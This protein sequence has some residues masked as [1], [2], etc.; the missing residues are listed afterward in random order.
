MWCEGG[1][2]KIELR[3]YPLDDAAPAGNVWVSRHE[4]QPVRNLAGCYNVTMSSELGRGERRSLSELGLRGSRV[5]LVFDWSGVDIDPGCFAVDPSG[6]L[7]DD[8]YFI[9]YNQ[10]ESPE[11]AIR[12]QNKEFSVDLGRLPGWVSRLVF[13]FTAEGAGIPS[14]I[15]GQAH[16]LEDPKELAR[17]S[18]SGRDYS[19]EHSLMVIELYQNRGEWKINALG[20]GFSGGLEALL[21]HFGAEVTSEPKSPPEPKGQE[22][23]SVKSTAPAKSAPKGFAEMFAPKLSSGITANR[24]DRSADT[25]DYRIYGA[26]T[27][28][29]EVELDPE[30]SVIAEAGAM[31]FMTDGI[32]MNTGLDGKGGVLGRLGRGLGRMLTGESFFITTFANQGQGKAQVGFAAPYP[33]T[34]IPLDLA[35]LGGQFICQ[36]DSFLCAAKGV[37]VETFFNRKIGAGL[38]GGEGFIL[39]KL[40]GE[41]LA[42]IHLGGTAIYREL[43]VGEKV[44]IDTGC[45]VGFSPSVKYNVEVN[46]GFKNMLFGGEGL[47]LATLEGPGPIFLQSLPFSRLVDRINSG[48]LRGGRAAA[49]GGQGQGIFDIFGG[50]GG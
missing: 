31:C 30:E 50:N 12:M 10:L 46:R 37:N 22:S 47:V 41:G 48:L 13:T 25:V 27:Q 1:R 2:H 19:S 9:F 21:N 29:V 45:V 7:V 33:G 32:V 20:Q 11:G 24:Q 16:V 3:V 6:H 38:F 35:E 36:K 44:R 5:T 18:F 28:L 15:R 26:E 43:G 17:F 42:F 14:L 8:R 4:G 34:I 23:P 49:R 39:Q 40:T